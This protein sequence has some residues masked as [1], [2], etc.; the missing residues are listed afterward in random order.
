MKKILSLIILF[1]TFLIAIN[2]LVFADGKVHTVLVDKKVIRAY[3]DGL[4][5]DKTIVMLSGWGTENPIDDFMSLA[6]KLASDYKVVILEYF[7]YGRSSIVSKDR[8]NKIMVEEIR[9]SLSALNIKPPYIIMPH[10][11]SGLYSLYYANNYP[12][13][14]SA[15]VGIDASVPQ[16]QLERWT[17]TSFKEITEE[18]GYN[19]C[20]VN[21]WNK[22]YD[23]SE[24]LKALKYPAGIPTL[25]FLA[26]EQIKSVDEMIKLGQMKTPWI[27][28]NLNILTNRDT[29]KI[30]VIDGEHYLHHSNFKKIYEITKNFIDMNT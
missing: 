2:H 24:E 10:S 13:E 6:N 19:I 27:D 8:S 14:V 23:N 4:K 3:I 26:T 21:Q 9:A 30:E 1:F 25:L 15:V 20:M 29:Q 18:S 5:H 16:K 11:M 7:G 22:F 12:E 17:K 28:I